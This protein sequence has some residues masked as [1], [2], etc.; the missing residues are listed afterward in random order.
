MNDKH[1][2]S[3]P[4][5]WHPN[6]DFTECTCEVMGYTHDQKVENELIKIRKLLEKKH[7]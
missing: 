6:M 1:S 3:C 2:P 5:Y 4:L 7:D